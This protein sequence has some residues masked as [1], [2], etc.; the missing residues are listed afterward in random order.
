MNAPASDSKPGFFQSLF[1]FQ[2]ESLIVTRIVPV[3]YAIGVIGAALW[4]LFFLFAGITNGG[5]PAIIAIIVAPL[6]FLAAV[7]YLR[8]ILE[9]VLVLFRISDH[10]SEVNSKLEPG[11]G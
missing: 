3:I 6:G 7:I 10:V 11:S 9:A 1:D 4:G 5:S 8:V 2:F